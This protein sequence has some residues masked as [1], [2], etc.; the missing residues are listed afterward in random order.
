M[1]AEKVIY[2][3]IENDAGVTA[4]IS[5][6]LFPSR[7]PQNTTMPAL[8]YQVIS[9][10]ELTPIDA[11]AGYQVVRTRVQITA[12]AKNY[13]EVKNTLEAVRIACLYKSGTIAGVKVISITRDSVGPD[14]RDDDLAFYIQSI[15][16][17]VM[18][19]ES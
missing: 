11:Q 1:R 7:M 19:Y 6:R 2:S 13:S 10:N 16:F 12:M 9:A 3:L 14:L 17:I 15:D 4:L 8:V 5:G 18:H